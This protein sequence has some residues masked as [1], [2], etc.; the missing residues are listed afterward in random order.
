MQLFGGVKKRLP[1]DSLVRGDI[2]V[3]LMGDPGMGKTTLLK[4]AS[5]LAPRSVNVNGAQST[6]VGVT[7]AATPS[8]GESDPWELQAGAIVLADHGLA[9]IDRFDGL[10]EEAQV[11]LEGPMAQQVLNVSKASVTTTL[12]AQSAVLATAN[13]KYG[14]FDQYEPIG[15]QIDLLPALI[16]RFDL[17]F[18]FT[19]QPDP[20]TDEELAEH[21][22][23]TN[24]AGEVSAKRDNVPN[25]EITEAD[26]EN[27]EAV[28]PDI[29]VEFL[30]KYIA[31]AKRNVYPTISEAA[32]DSIEEFYVDMRAKC[33]D[34]DA[35]APLSA[36]KLEGVV[37]LAEASAR[38]RLSDVVEEEDAE[39][40]IKIVRS[41]LEDVGIDPETGEF[42]ADV[43]K[44]GTSKA[45][46][47][48]IKDMK[49][50]IS[51]IAEEFDEGAPIRE[52][53]DRA[54]EV[55]LSVEEAEEEVDYLR[56]KGEV[57][58]PTED[59]LRTT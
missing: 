45:Q 48:R 19:D 1:D 43:V 49:Q 32:K 9:S 22:L 33:A 2:H 8:S 58:R 10:P 51:D 55:G 52:V 14:R 28:T 23:T 26:S 29:D 53:L 11:A 3:L 40:V 7:A 34:E 27:V 21:V 12:P 18:T 56:R 59:H 25:A 44:T 47:D 42:D 31:Y 57:Y 30:R 50:L 41:A 35:P 6:K 15:E 4:A 16:S 54:G 37:R 36:R 17:I 39:R 46:R 13:P 24:Q 5:N 38:I 20:D